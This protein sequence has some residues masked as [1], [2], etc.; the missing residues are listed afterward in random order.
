MAS[1]AA[2]YLEEE[3]AP[4]EATPLEYP[5]LRLLCRP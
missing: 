2:A 3:A 4:I 5:A 1:E